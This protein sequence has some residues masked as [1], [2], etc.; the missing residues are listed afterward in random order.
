M[1]DYLENEGR[2]V[3]EDMVFLRIGR[4]F[5]VGEARV[6]VG[7]NEGENNRLQ[8]LA[9]GRGIPHM[10][11]SGHMGPV[12]VLLGGHNDEVIGR[13]AAITAR[14]SDAPRDVQVDVEYHDGAIS[15]Q[16]AVAVSD[17]ELEN[18]RI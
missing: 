1:R 15:I 17:D 9:E 7:R 14:Y 10:S 16:K 13:S 4:H 3:L 12:T 5:R 18:M 11:V 2:P 6:I 8:S